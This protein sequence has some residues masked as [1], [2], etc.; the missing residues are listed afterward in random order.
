MKT[1]TKP[2]MKIN[3]FPN[4]NVLTSSGT[5]TGTDAAMET[6][7]EENIGSTVVKLDRNDMTLVF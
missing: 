3:A 4:E 7:S 5:A 6:W 2:E 1:Y